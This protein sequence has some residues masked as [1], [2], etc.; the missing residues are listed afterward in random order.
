M[1]LTTKYALAGLLWGLVLG[2]GVVAI[3]TGLGVAVLFTLVYDKGPWGE[4]AGGVLY[5]LAAL[6]WVGSAVFCA[7][8]GY[9]HGW[10]VQRQGAR[11]DGS[12]M[13]DEHRRAH[14]VAAAAVLTALLGGYQLYARN[15]ALTLRQE[16]LEELLRE[17]HA[18]RTMAVLERRDGFGLDVV[19]D[20]SGRREGRYRL[21]VFVQDERGRTL[22]VVRTEFDAGTREI[23][24]RVPV[25]YEA[26]M[27][28]QDGDSPAGDVGDG[29]RRLPLV[30]TV[31]LTPLLGTGELRVLPGHVARNY[32]AEDSPFHSIRQANHVLLW[33]AAGAR[34]WIVGRDGELRELA[35]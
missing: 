10:R 34:R 9:V 18:V 31:R 28:M 26:I 15:A 12:S 14:L 27:P 4:G 5:G 30:L 6:G 2:Y 33:R 13:R 23:H 20:A 1:S 21:E 7:G 24:E 19:V 25:P 8:V 16:Y 17:R 22:H 11:G 32:M 3:T 29:A 35:R